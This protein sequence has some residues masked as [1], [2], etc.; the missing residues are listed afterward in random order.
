MNLDHHV[1]N[2]LLRELSSSLIQVD[3]NGTIVAWA[4]A[5]E[6]MFGAPAENVVGNVGVV[7]LFVTRSEGEE[8][9]EKLPESERVEMNAELARLSGGSFPSKI[10]FRVDSKGEGYVGLATDVSDQEQARE[11]FNY[12]KVYLDT[13]LEISGDAIITSD[14]DGVMMMFNEGAESIFRREALDALGEDMFTL[15][16][17]KDDLPEVKV[18]LRDAGHIRDWES[19]VMVDGETGEQEVFLEIT[20][21]KTRDVRGQESA[22]VALIRDVTARKRLEEERLA[23]ERVQQEMRIARGVQLT[24]LPDRPPKIDAADIAARIEFCDDIGGDLFDFSHPRSGKLGVSIGDVSAHGVGPAIVMSSAKAMMNTLEQ[25]TEDLEHMCFLLNNLLEKTTED[26]RF[27]TMFYGLIDLE[28]KT[29]EYVNAG[30]DPPIVF[31]PAT[32]Q[33]EELQSTG[34]ALGILPSERFR[35]GDVVR[36]S[37]GDMMLLTTDGIWEAADPGGDAFGKTRVF[38]ILRDMHDQPCQA[39]LDELFDR[40]SDHCGGQSA[41]DDQTA[42]LFRFR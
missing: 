4:D 14:L 3:R 25:Y 29:L 41:K 36:F 40:V 24:M 10:G 8:L 34:M 23:N 17:A 15:L 37:P 32:G 28:E 20:I 39:V 1:V 35:L 7:D 5:N 42:V 9:L 30:H 27:I 16:F 22:M 26:D 18:A 19:K 33:F 12:L 38:D 11:N 2:Q 6:R 21:S 31:R 13:V